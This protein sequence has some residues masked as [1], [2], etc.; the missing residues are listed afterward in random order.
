M[1]AR[2][3]V[4]GVKDQD[5]IFQDASNFLLPPIKEQEKNWKNQ[6]GSV[7]LG[8]GLDIFTH[9]SIIQNPLKQVL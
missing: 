7:K 3:I 1:N 4:D 9:G 8:I 2:V 5:R 6:Q